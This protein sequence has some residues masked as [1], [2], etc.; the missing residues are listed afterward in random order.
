MKRFNFKNKKPSII[1]PKNKT[2]PIVNEG[3]RL[4]G[5]SKKKDTTKMETDTK[6]KDS[7]TISSNS[8]NVRG[9][10]FYEYQIGSL[11]LNRI[12]EDIKEKEVYFKRFVFEQ[13]LVNFFKLKE[14]AKEDTNKGHKL[15]HIGVK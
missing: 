10:P 14:V 2:A 15:K 7:N 13:F 1:L 9:L 11:R 8:D 5:K 4:D 12:R 6:S 3:Y